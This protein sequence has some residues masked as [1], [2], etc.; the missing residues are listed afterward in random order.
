MPSS[1]LDAVEVQ[2]TSVEKKTPG[3]AREQRFT[4][5][6]HTSPTYTRTDISWLRASC[7]SEQEAVVTQH[8]STGGEETSKK[9]NSLDTR[10]SI[11]Q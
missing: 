1:E 6:K 4:R 2:H 10:A 8:A 9:S 5:N 7:L 11:K 3:T